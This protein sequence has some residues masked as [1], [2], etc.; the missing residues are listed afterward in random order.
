MRRDACLPP[1][2]LSESSVRCVLNHSPPFGC[3]ARPNL[4]TLT[5]IP[6]DPIA[7]RY[8]F[9]EFG[10]DEWK[11]DRIR[12]RCAAIMRRTLPGDRLIQKWNGVAREVRDEMFVADWVTEIC[13]EDVA[14]T[15][16]QIGNFTVIDQDRLTV[17]ALLRWMVY[18]RIDDP[19]FRAAVFHVES[20][21]LD[22][23]GQNY[24]R[25]RSRILYGYE[26]DESAIRSL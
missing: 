7:E 22:E 6:V 19:P 5:E 24:P 20:S 14:R 12:E 3:L 17:D 10:P 8:D 4:R 21:P 11:M 23:P 26:R 2:V 9:D 25:N 18:G 1:P 13:G 16:F 15:E